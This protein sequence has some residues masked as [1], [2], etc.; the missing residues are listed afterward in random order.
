MNIYKEK[1]SV[2][3]REDLEYLNKIEYNHDIN[4]ETNKCEKVNSILIK[5][6]HLKNLNQIR[7]LI[8]DLKTKNKFYQDYFKKL[9]IREMKQKSSLII[10]V[11]KWMPDDYVN[12]CMK[13]QSKFSFGRWKNHCRVCGNIF[14]STCCNRFEAFQPFYL[15]P[16]RMCETCF[17]DKK[18]EK[19]I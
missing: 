4:L 13:C 16:V 19:Y 5:S 2:L 7:D 10:Q 17:L 3:I 11:P 6:N 14:C 9:K 18:Y 1:I 12:L 8:L 15:E